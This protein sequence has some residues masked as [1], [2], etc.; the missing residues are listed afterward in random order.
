MNIH[1]KLASVAHVCDCVPGVIFFRKLLHTR[2]RNVELEQ[3]SQEI[4]RRKY[5]RELKRE[6]KRA[7]R[8]RQMQLEVC[9]SVDFFCWLSHNI[10]FIVFQF[11]CSEIF[12]SFIFSAQVV[13][14]EATARTETRTT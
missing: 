14:L 11:V 13:Q 7:Q 9:F 12:T 6:Q 8:D 4:Q 3:R 1:S 10:V 5:L 2:Q